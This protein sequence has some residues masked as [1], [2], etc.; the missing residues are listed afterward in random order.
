MEASA[1]GESD[2]YNIIRIGSSGSPVLFFL[3]KRK[4]HLE[5]F[6]HRG[7]F[8]PIMSCAL[9]AEAGFGGLVSGECD[10]LQTDN[11]TGQGD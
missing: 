6:V 2:S 11:A 3:N 4:A 9:L 8:S 7:V 1:A 5:Q 10:P